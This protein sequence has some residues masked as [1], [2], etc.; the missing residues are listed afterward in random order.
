MLE[1]QAKRVV[2]HIERARAVWPDGA[3][4][5]VSHAEVIRAALLYFLGLSLDAWRLFEICSGVNHDV[6]GR[7]SEGATSCGVNEAVG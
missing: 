5:L 1:V 6:A 3:L 2:R 4:A 7:T